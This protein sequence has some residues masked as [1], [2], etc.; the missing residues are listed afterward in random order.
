MVFWSL[1]RF[2]AGG[3]AVRMLP[4]RLRKLDQAPEAKQRRSKTVVI[5]QGKKVANTIEESMGQRARSS[6]V[7][8]QAVARDL[9][10]RETR[11]WEPRLSTIRRVIRS[12]RPDALKSLINGFAGYQACAS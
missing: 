1:N 9:S 12:T 6:E 7:F 5:E 3:K 11:G 2:Y 10:S 4:M 8:E